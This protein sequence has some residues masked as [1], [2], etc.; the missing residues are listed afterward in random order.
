MPLIEALR[1]CEH[2][3]K[4]QLYAFDIRSDLQALPL[5]MRKATLARLLAQTVPT[6]YA[7]RAS[8]RHR[9]SRVAR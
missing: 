5:S 9:S 4:V 8:D 6:R 2:D 3:D 7:A 1:S